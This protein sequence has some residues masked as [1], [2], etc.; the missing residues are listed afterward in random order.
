M[1]PVIYKIGTNIF[2]KCHNRPYTEI[3]NP[4]TRNL[5]AYCV[6]NPFRYTDPKGK[7]IESDQD[8]DYTS[9]YALLVLT[10]LY[11][12]AMDADEKDAIRV[13]AEDVRKMQVKKIL[14][15]GEQVIRRNIM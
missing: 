10:Y 5:Y 9:Q 4:Q 3:Q 1:V 6:G 14:A 2:L 7:W 11:N 8:L 13:T 15:F 12:I